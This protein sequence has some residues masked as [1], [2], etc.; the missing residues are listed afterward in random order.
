MATL[1]IQKIVRTGLNPTMAAATAGGDE[2]PNSGRE[3]FRVANG[4]GGAITVTFVT[5]EVRDTL[6]VADRTVSVPAGEFRYVGPFPRDIYN[7][8]NGRVGVTYSGVTSLTVAA[9]SVG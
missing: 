7:N 1:A 2:F 5:P 6:A 3:F 8:V 9:L 4:S